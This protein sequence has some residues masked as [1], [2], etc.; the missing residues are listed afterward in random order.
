ML[1]K[2]IMTRMREI[3]KMDNFWTLKPFFHLLGMRAISYK[4]EFEEKLLYR[5]LT[6]VIKYFI[7]T[8][9]PTEY[10][11]QSLK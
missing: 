3:F 2:Y 1:Q 9:L 10:Q 8:Y 6:M 5:K 4:N 7:A 11:K